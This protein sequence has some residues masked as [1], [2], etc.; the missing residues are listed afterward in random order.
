MNFLK[1]LFCSHD[2]RIDLHTAWSLDVIE[3]TATIECKRCKKTFP[4]S[5]GTQNIMVEV[6]HQKSVIEF[7]NMMLRNKS[8]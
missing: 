3:T 2:I 5:Y 8:K 6:V 1:K 7:E 4:Y